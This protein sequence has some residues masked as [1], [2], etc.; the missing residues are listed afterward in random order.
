ML[1]GLNEIMCQSLKHSTW[2]L[3]NLQYELLS[4]QLLHAVQLL[5]HVQLF[6]IPWTTAHQAFLSFTIWIPLKL[7][8]IEL[9]MPSNIHHPTKTEFGPSL[10]A[11]W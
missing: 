7:M 8:S 1:E 5:S 6:V 10:M 4:K 2:A 3:G 9:V 11:Q